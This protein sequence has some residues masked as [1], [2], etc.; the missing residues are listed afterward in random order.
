[1]ITSAALYRSL[2]ECHPKLQR[3]VVWCHSCGGRMAVD[4]AKC[5]A[6]GWPLC[7]GH[8]MSIDSPS[9]RRKAVTQ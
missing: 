9:E 5:F 3:G 2:A 7:C 4:V 1:M 8:T 6:E